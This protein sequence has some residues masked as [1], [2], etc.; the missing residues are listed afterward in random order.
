ML[1]FFRILQGLGGGGLAPS[2]QSIIADIVPPEKRGI[3]FAIYG[4]GVIFA[5]AI[6][7]TVGGWITDNYSWHWIFFINVPIGLI[8]LLLTWYFVQEPKS[9]AHE[10]ERLDKEGFKIDWLGITLFALGI[11][12]LEIVLDEGNRKDWFESSFIVGFAVVAVVALVIGITWEFYQK[13]PAVDVRMLLNRNFASSFV[14]LFA[15]GFILFGSTFLLPLMTQTLFGYDAVTA[16]E[17]ISPGGF[18]VMAMMPIVGGV[19]ISRV[20]ARWLILFGLLVSAA[21]LWNLASLNLQAGY[22]DLAWARAYQAFGLAFLFVPINTAAYTGIPAGKSNNVSALMNLARNIG[23]SMGIAILSTLLTRRSQF[24]IN[25]S[26]YYTSNYNP[27]FVDAINRTTQVLQERGLSVIDAA[28]QARGLMWAQVL[29]QS[30]MLAFLDAFYF[31]MWEFYQKHPAVDVRMLLNRNF[32]SSFVLLFALGFILFGS[33]F[34]LPLMTQTLF[35]YDA[36]TAG[37]VISPGGFVV[38]AMMPIVGGVLI[39]RVQARW[40]ILFGLLVSAAALWNLAS[41]NLQAGYSDLAWARAYQAFGLAFL[42]VPINT[43]AYTGIPAG[44][45]NNVSALMNLARNIGGS[46]GIAILSTLLTRRSQFH[47]NSS[48]YYTSNYNPNFVDAINRTTQVL[49]ERGLSVIDAANQARGLM[50]AQVLKQ[51]S[52]LAFLDAF[53]FLMIL[54]LCAIPLA[55]L[56]KKNKPGQGAGGH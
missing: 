37:E 16:G 9:T 5:P 17:V 49:Q 39:S 28:N 15:L 6:G 30:S 7:P 4:L 25:S 33:T 56:L 52:M 51:S 21:A 43:A 44:K 29:K 50:W 11:G 24:H 47:I 22:S 10:R 19:L 35:G 54:I 38:M 26:G 31:L 8:S 20:Q 53:Y 48:G 3:A 12:A 46:M 2:E 55:F 23:G 18:V 13:H 42:F 27:N 45:S 14:L 32:A 41:L 40:L 34:L 1:I 36:V